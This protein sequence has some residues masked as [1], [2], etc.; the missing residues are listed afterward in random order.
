MIGDSIG[1][2][3]WGTIGD[4]IGSNVGSSIGIILLTKA[5]AAQIE[6]ALGYH[7]VRGLYCQTVVFA[8]TI[9]WGV[10]RLY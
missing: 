5:T 4:S 7:T 1:S 3:I 6:V 9:V 10:G 2:I 8:A